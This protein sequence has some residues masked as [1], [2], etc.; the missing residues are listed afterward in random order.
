VSIITVLTITSNITNKIMWKANQ[1]ISSPGFEVC[2]TCGTSYPE[3]TTCLK[4][5]RKGNH[6][7]DNEKQKGAH[8]N[9]G[10][11][12]DEPKD[13]RNKTW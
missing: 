7:L 2:K 5:G 11:T 3:C 6:Q 1:N 8:D 13:P 4:Y 10:F 12:N 9:S